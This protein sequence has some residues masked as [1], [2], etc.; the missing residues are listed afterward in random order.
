MVCFILD[1]RQRVYLFSYI[2]AWSRRQYLCFTESQDF[3]TTIRHH[4]VEVGA[5]NPWDWRILAN[6][7]IDEL[8]YE[9]GTIDASLPFDELRRRSDITARARAAVK[10]P[11]F[12]A[13]IRAGLPGPGDVQ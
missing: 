9:R 10:E 11:G 4:A 2:L 13:L 6:G 3:A 1:G 5:G 8:G 7:Y 12:S